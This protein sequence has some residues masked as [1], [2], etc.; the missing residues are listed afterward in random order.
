MERFNEIVTLKDRYKNVVIALGTFDGLHIGHQ[1][2]INKAVAR[3]R[4]C[5]GTSV[6]F[7]FSNHPLSMLDPE[8]CPPQLVTLQE[9]IKL[10]AGM[11]VDVL[12]TVPFTPSFL[13]LKAE[14]FIQLLADHFQ[15]R[16]IVVGPNYS[17]GSKS[18]GTPE[19]LRAAGC[20]YHFFVDVEP[21]VKIDDQVVSSTLIRQ[22]ISEGRVSQ[23][24]RFLGR[25]FALAGQVVGGEKR[26]RTIGFPTANIKIDI[27]LA[28][29]ANGVYAV[30][31]FARGQIYNGV[32]NIGTNPTF[33]GVQKRLEV[34]L[35]DFA[36]NLYDSTIEVHFLAWLRG[37]TVFKDIEELKLQIIRDIETAQRY[38]PS[39]T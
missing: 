27:S 35:L 33:Q 18:A 6:V 20:N 29:P 8:R 31:V 3:A 38:F 7:T 9:K 12:F 22:L 30:R 21:A 25:P 19:L 28:I 24:E 34:H 10:L 1:S 2:V 13:T 14:Q 26:G 37:E 39:T 32:A 17:F 11:G 16:H 5:D 36:G 15:P 4:A 23:A